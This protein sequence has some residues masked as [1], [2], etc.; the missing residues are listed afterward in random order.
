[1][2][3]SDLKDPLVDDSRVSIPRSDGTRV[4]LLDARHQPYVIPRSDGSCISDQVRD[5]TYAPVTQPSIS[6][7]SDLVVVEPQEG[8]PN[9][10]NTNA[11]LNRAANSRPSISE[12]VEQVPAI[13]N[14]SDQ[15]TEDTVAHKP[16]LSFNPD[17]D[18]STS[19]KARGLRAVD[20]LDASALGTINS[21]LDHTRKDGRT[22][23]NA[24]REDG[25]LNITDAS[26]PN[27][28]DPDVWSLVRKCLA[29]ALEGRGM[30]KYD[31]NADYSSK[32]G[33]FTIG[34]SRLDMNGKG[35]P[36]SY[37]YTMRL[38]INRF[39]ESVQRAKIKAGSS[40][41]LAEISAN[42]KK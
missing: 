8:N 21:F 5:K 34:G 11:A 40:L 10:S 15:I 28:C 4:K 38:S 13:T 25:Q 30:H 26:I 18:P 24:F 39:A 27:L 7:L 12:T 42:M 6:D 22:N 20:N 31:T 17:A 19:S 2:S 16:L 41:S 32:V 3:F 1:M 9:L 35:E 37:P 36:V 14:P 23:Y 29:A 33:S